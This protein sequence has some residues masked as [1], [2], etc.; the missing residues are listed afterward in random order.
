[1]KE[2]YDRINCTLDGLEEFAQPAPFEVELTDRV[3]SVDEVSTIVD[4]L[5]DA[6]EDTEED[7]LQTVSKEASSNPG[8]SSD[9]ASSNPGASHNEASSSSGASP[10][11]LTVPPDPPVDLNAIQIASDFRYD[12]IGRRYPIDQYGYRM[13]K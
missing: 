8:A 5:G 12:A 13:K 1:M 11:V 10:S 2:R 3:V 6:H 7:A 9:A 4:R